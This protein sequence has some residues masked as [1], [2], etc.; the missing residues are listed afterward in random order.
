MTTFT[1]FYHYS[2]DRTF[3]MQRM[4]EK[5]IMAAK[6][7]WYRRYE[8]LFEYDLGKYE[9]RTIF[10]IH[11]GDTLDDGRYIIRH[12]LGG[13]SHSHR[14]RPGKMPRRSPGVTVT[15]GATERSLVEAALLLKVILSELPL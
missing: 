6:L 12:K 1:L 4:A 13:G 10:P 2:I 8:A 5:A 11:L 3:N 15:N 7:P 14:S 9:D